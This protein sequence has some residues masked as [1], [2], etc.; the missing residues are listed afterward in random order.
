MATTPKTDRSG[1]YSLRFS[2][3]ELELLKSFAE[4]EDMKISE[5][6]REAIMSLVAA[7]REPIVEVTAPA[8]ARV[9]I[10]GGEPTQNVTKNNSVPLFLAIAAATA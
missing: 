10:Y 9:Y 7:Q 3:K 6:V 8:D 1:V 2:D 4:R 5:V